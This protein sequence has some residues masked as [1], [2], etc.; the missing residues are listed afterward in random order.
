MEHAGVT[1]S[2]HVCNS[3][4]LKV[5]K[6]DPFFSQPFVFLTP[7]SNRTEAEDPRPR[8]FLSVEIR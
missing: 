6:P 4:E 1:E 7:D 5:R 2:T 8:L 3:L